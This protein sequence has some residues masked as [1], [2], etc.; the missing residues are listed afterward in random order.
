MTEKSNPLKW[1]SLV[2]LIAQTTALVLVLRF[3]KTRK[4]YGELPYISSTAI[5]VA[6]VVKFVTCLI[7][8]FKNNGSVNASVI[9]NL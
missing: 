3:S 7:I 8:L 4:T 9:L 1:I 2:V 6:E 5:L